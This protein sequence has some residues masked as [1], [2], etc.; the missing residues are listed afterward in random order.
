MLVI[1]WCDFTFKTSKYLDLE[2][3]QAKSLVLNVKVGVSVFITFRDTARWR[4]KSN[5]CI[6]Y[7][8]RLLSDFYYDQGSLMKLF[9]YNNNTTAFLIPTF[10]FKT[11]IQLFFIASPSRISITLARQY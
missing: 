3:S 8:L 5:R 4:G 7:T 2:E 10:T 1:L 9:R 11:S 6:F